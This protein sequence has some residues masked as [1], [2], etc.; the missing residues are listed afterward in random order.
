MKEDWLGKWAMN[1]M[2]IKCLDAQVRTFRAL[3]GRRY[4]GAQGLRPV[5]I[6][7]LEAFCGAVG[8]AARG[9]DGIR[10]FRS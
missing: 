8:G 9:V 4:V 6:G 10:S 5:E 1:Q 3:A 2:L 7:G